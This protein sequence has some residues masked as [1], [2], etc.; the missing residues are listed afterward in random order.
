MNRFNFAGCSGVVLDSC[1]PHGVW[2][3][4]DELRRIAEFVRGGGLDLARG[5]ERERMELER[6][7]LTL[8]AEDA[9]RSASSF[10]PRMPDSI[11]SARGILD[12]LIGLKG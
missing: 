8:A 12:Y 1:K 10:Q 6:R 4:P 9:G 2:F 3:D 11:A 5:K 7:R